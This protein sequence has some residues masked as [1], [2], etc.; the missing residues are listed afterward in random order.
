MGFKQNKHTGGSNYVTIGGDGTL[1]M[2]CEED[3]P[4]AVARELTRGPNEGSLIH[5]LHFGSYEGHIVNAYIKQGE[6]YGDTL[7]RSASQL[8][9][10]CSWSIFLASHY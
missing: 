5:E 9:S 4:G 6:K 7:I 8:T 1:V 2:R 3:T 10:N